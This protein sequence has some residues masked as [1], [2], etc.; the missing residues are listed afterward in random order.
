[1]PPTAQDRFGDLLGELD[2]IHHG[3]SLESSGGRD[4]PT[5]A[6]VYLH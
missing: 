1:M 5:I 6:G 4:P 3:T 2:R